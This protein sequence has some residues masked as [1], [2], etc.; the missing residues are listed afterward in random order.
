[1]KLVKRNIAGFSLFVDKDDPG[2]SA[3]LKRTK[4]FK[5][6]HRE[7]EF[8][9]IIES[10]ISKNDKVC[11]LGANIGYVTLIMAR[12]VGEKGQIVA[13]EPSPHNF[14]ILKEMVRYN[15][16][17]ENVELMHYA[18]SNFKKEIE[19]H[20]SSA[21]NLHSIKKTRNTIESIK[22]NAISLDEIYRD[23]VPPTFIKMDIEGGELEAL[24]GMRNI[25]SNK[26]NNMRILMEIHP[27]YY[28]HNKFKEELEFLFNHGFKV[29][30]MTSAGT[31]EPDFLK[32]NGYK[33]NKVYTTGD[34]SRGVYEDIDNETAI[35]ACCQNHSQLV[36]RRMIGIIKRF[37]KNPFNNIER[38][39]ISEKIV[40]AIC[41][42]R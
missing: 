36:K 31:A 22:I 3:T 5:K 16:L 14:K 34:F 25:T 40:R 9:D 30:Y 2:I 20:L 17:E 19:F 24:Q 38:N 6:W 7:P 37:I 12:L 35:Q 1:M 18:I 21:S 42:E 41:L 32:K 4:G 28:D 11:D 13:I 26:Q 23:R 29:K 39:F 27:M 8:M 10:S 15:D 33:P